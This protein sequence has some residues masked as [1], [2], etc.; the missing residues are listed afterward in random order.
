MKNISLITAAALIVLMTSLSGCAA[1]VRTPPPPALVEV[2]PVVPFHGAI[3]I[4][5]Y[6]DH[7]HG[8]YTWVPGRYMNP[9]HR[10][11]VWVPGHW[12]QHR[13]GWKWKKG[14]WK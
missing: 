7:R 11:A 14:Y 6:Y 8:R 9:P 10:G 12:Q 2:R 13:R 3:W 4:D 5:G 1:S